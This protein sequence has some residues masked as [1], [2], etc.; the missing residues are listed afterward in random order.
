MLIRS[1]AIVLVFSF[2]AMAA[3]ASDVRVALMPIAVHAAGEDSD[4][5]REGLSE[6]IAAR[7]D[8]YEGV[9][10]V[11]PPV[12]GAAPGNPETARAVAEGAGA[13]FVLYGSFTRFGN[14][15]SLDLR[16]VPTAAGAPDDLRRL[17]IQSGELAEIIPKLDTLAQRVVRYTVAAGKSPVARGAGDAT[18]AAAAT[19]P[20][21]A[22]YR[23][24][25][26][27]VEELERALIP[28]VA[29]KAAEGE[30]LVR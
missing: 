28:P 27:R 6:M 17:F 5:L 2:S 20:T 15:A 11:R 7:I 19:G 21:A 22:E 3:S 10:V 25:L 23:A 12:E 24:L 8:Q 9:T 14:G 30:V 13:D 4:Y 29:E 18:A 1:L 26:Q 16:C